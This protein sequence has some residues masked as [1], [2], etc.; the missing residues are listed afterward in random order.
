MRRQNRELKKT[1]ADANAAIAGLSRALLLPMSA[2]DISHSVL[3][4]ARK[5]TGS[6]FGYVAYIDPDTGHLVS[7]TLTGDILVNF[8]EKDKDI[9]FKE[10]SGLWGWVLESKKPLLTNS[11]STDLRSSGTPEG[12][13]PIRQFLSVPALIGENLIGQVAVIYRR[14]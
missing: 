3:E 12:H 14:A 2:E 5:L 6:R 4:Q 13:I 9:V 7:S 8:R 1:E 11:P 10:F